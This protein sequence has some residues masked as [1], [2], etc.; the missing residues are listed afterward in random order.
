MDNE[1]TNK[2]L[3]VFSDASEKAIAAV[4]YL[5]CQDKENKTSIGFVLGK[6]KVAPKHGHTIPRLELCAAVLAAEI[7]EFI[8]DNLDIPLDAVRFTLT[9]RWFSDISITRPD[10]S[11]C[12]LEIE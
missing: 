10:G 11:T 3:H 12:M 5:T 1:F 4:A 7:A 2:E 8:S 9:A 6:A